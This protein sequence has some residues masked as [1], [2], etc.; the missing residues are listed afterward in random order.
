MDVVV[1]LSVVVSV[2]DDA[3]A[4]A[5]LAGVDD[6]AT[7]SFSKV[8]SLLSIGGTRVTVLFSLLAAEYTY[9]QEYMSS[10]IAAF[11]NFPRFERRILMASVL[12][13]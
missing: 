8:A 13:P 3:A 12:A 7:T 5:A 4:A 11:Q 6:M 9:R 10:R 1:V 2:V